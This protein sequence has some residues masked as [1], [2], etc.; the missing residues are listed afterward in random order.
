MARPGDLAAIDLTYRRRVS[1][2]KIIAKFV[3]R[4]GHEKS[5]DAK[6]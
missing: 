1:D 2:I 5:K 3:S 6:V 4:S